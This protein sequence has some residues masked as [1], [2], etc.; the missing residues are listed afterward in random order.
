MH[1]SR[2]MQSACQ[3]LACWKVDVYVGLAILSLGF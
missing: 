3:I 1:I 2:C